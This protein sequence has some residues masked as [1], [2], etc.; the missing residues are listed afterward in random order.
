MA[1]KS[2]SEILENR[3]MGD[4]PFSQEGLDITF[5][6]NKE[7]GIRSI[8]IHGVTLS[9]DSK[10][11]EKDPATYVAEQLSAHQKCH[12]SVKEK[13][14]DAYEKLNKDLDRES[15][16][17]HILQFAPNPEN[18]MST[19]NKLLRLI[20]APLA[21]IQF[22]TVKGLLREDIQD[23]QFGVQGYKL[24]ETMF[25]YGKN[26]VDERLEQ[27]NGQLPEA[28]STDLE[29]WAKVQGDLSYSYSRLVDTANKEVQMSKRRYKQLF[30]NSEI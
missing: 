18:T 17:E 3:K 20:L 11:F 22:K 12:E 19:V 15:R 9:Y 13:L 8:P 28:V 2:L 16:I 21:W 14:L 30:P 26:F 1:K 25:N 7:P 10:R 29:E 6:V 4:I 24:I 5:D 23:R 27:S